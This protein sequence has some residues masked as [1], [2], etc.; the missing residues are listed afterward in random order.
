MAVSGAAFDVSLREGLQPEAP[1]NVPRDLWKSAK[2]VLAC[3][4]RP[5]ASLTSVSLAGAWSHLLWRL[6]DDA[7]E[8]YPVDEHSM[9]SGAHI[10]YARSRSQ[11]SRMGVSCRDRGAG[12]GHVVAAGG[13]D[14]TG[15]S[16]G[17]CHEGLGRSGECCTEVPRGLL[18][19]AVV[20]GGRFGVVLRVHGC[21]AACRW[22]WSSDGG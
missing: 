21:R 12:L 2:A 16:R 15:V 7:W 17:K 3:E 4:V 6:I 19:G 20:L 8:L 14:T 9:A 11:G 18:T 5:L 13:C 1:Q 22:R 10:R